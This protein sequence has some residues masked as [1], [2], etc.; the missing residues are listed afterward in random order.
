MLVRL[1]SLL[2]EI[3]FLGKFIWDMFFGS[4]GFQKVL[5]C[6]IH[7]FKNLPGP[8]LCCIRGGI[9]RIPF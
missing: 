3:S 1:F 6:I 8:F 4:F 7:L 9:L 2:L 5:Q